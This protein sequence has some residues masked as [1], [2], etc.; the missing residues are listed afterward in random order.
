[1]E[2]HQTIGHIARGIFNEK[3]STNGVTLIV[4]ITMTHLLLSRYQG[5]EIV[6]SP[7]FTYGKS[8]DS[9]NERPK[10]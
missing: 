1:V 2:K 4:I 10:D 6:Q 9:D 5:R 3:T 7:S 8:N